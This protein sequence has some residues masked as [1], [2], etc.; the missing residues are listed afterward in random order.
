MHDSLKTSAHLVA[1]ETTEIDNPCVEDE[2][3]PLNAEQSAF[4]DRLLVE[5]V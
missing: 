1:A 4:H 5:V 2:V 3:L